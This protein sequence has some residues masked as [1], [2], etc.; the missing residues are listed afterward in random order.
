MSEHT[1]A[2]GQL[3]LDPRRRL[4]LADGRT[5][6]LQPRP[7]DILEYLL[8]KRDRIV[9]REEIVSHVWR[10][11]VVAANNLTVQMS[12]LRRTLA[13][14]GAGGLIITIPGRGY[15]FVGE[16]LELPPPAPPATSVQPL[17]KDNSVPLPG[18]AS[19][20]TRTVALAFACLPIAITG[21]VVWHLVVPSTLVAPLSVVARVKVAASPDEVAIRPDGYQKVDYVFSVIDLV[22][23]QLET[24]DFQFYLTSGEHVGDSNIRGRIYGGS[25]AI[26]GGTTGVYHNNIYLPPQIAAIGKSRGGGVVQLKHVFHLRDAKGDEVNVPAVL[27]ILVGA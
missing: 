25:F 14:S 26:R 18:A 1:I 19:K 22:D 6:E 10:G 21:F 7:F 24:E 2:F 5:V 12:I 8:A 23:L 13:E 15:R 9:T 11:H 4:L 20:R 17:P 3:V 27:R 16:V